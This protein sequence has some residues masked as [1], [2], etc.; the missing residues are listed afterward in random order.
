MCRTDLAI[1][2]E[3]N[4]KISEKNYENGEVKVTEIEVKEESGNFKKGRYITLQFPDILNIFST[5]EIEEEI[6]NSLKKMLPEAA[7]RVLVA[8]LGNSEITCDSI[9]PNTVS[10]ILATRHIAGNFAD[11]LGL[12]G[13]KSISAVAPGVLGKTGI[14]S[15]ELIKAAADKIKPQAVIVIDA[16]AAGSMSRLF[17]TIQFSNSGIAPGSGVKNSRKEL[18]E[19]TLGVPV[20]DIGV[21][22]V[23]DADTIASEISGENKKSE[24]QMILTP[25]DSD[26]LSKKI[27]DVIANALNIFLQPEIAPEVI[28]ALV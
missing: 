12:R 10:G 18:S 28:K 2:F 13:L 17:K 27:S 7:E 6:E 14:E 19:S 26:I 21:P 16:L 9:G 8:G 3:K 25:K 5:E 4:E 22:T 11:R 24:F 1:E 20:I 23:M 15:A